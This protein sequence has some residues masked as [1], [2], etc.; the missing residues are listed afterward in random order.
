[1]G[2]PM[3]TTSSRNTITWCVSFRVAGALGNRAWFLGNGT[4]GSAATSLTNS[5]CFITI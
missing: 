4:L 5:F 1:M 3:S 2:T